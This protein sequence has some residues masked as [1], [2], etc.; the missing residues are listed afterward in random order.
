MFS[1]S[2]IFS[3]DEFYNVSKCNLVDNNLID[4]IDTQIQYLWQ[5]IENAVVKAKKSI[6]SDRYD[7]T[8]ME[9]KTMAF[10]LA[11]LGA[12]TLSGVRLLARYV[13]MGEFNRYIFM[14]KE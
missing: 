10:I 9:Y 3:T 13:N 7:M 2:Y 6:L 11:G 8:S 4:N 12:T 1:A 5:E 14:F